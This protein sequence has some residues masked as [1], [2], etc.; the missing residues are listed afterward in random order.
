MNLITAVNIPC[1]S[2]FLTADFFATTYEQGADGSEAFARLA[3]RRKSHRRF[4]GGAPGPTEKP[5]SSYNRLRMR[6]GEDIVVDR[7]YTTDC[8]VSTFIFIC[9]RKKI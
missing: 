7:V 2:Y 4:G 1:R 8:I 3:E 6:L 5:C 9:R